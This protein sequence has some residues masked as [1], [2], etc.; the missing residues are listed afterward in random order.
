MRVTASKIKT[1]EK[2]ADK[3]ALAARK[4]KK[5]QR[6]PATNTD[7]AAILG[8]MVEKVEA[9]GGQESLALLALVGAR[10]ETKPADAA[11]PYAIM[12]LHAA[13]DTP[14]LLPHVGALLDGTLPLN[15]ERAR[16][17]NGLPAVVKRGFCHILREA[18]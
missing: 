13:L 14:A 16:G 12:G 9:E 10:A 5:M 8:G 2:R 1:L 11:L 3:A 6:R 18:K 4:R 7:V 15:D 17:E